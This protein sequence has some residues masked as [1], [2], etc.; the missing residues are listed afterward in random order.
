MSAPSG[1]PG[2]VIFDCDGVLVDS[3]RIAVEID[4]AVLARVG[5]NLSRQQVVERFVGRSAS[6]MEAAIEQH[7]GDRLTPELQAEFDQLYTDAF[8]RDLEPVTGIRDTLSQLDGPTCVASSSTPESLRRKL[9][10]VGLW[11]HFAGRVFSAEQ[12][13]NGKPAPDLFL[14]AAERMGQSPARCVVVEDSSFGV[15]AARAAGMHAFAFKTE[16]VDPQTLRGPHTTLF[17]DMSELPTLIR[18]HQNG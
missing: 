7:L 16:L 17:S 15:Q 14:Y 9:T 2:L 1:R 4:V 8:A 13:A 12:V 6:V 11:D 3:E 18:S 10:R 5:L